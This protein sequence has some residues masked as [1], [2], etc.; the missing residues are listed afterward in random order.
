MLKKV[1]L[2][3]CLLGLI[4]VLPAHASPTNK[5]ITLS[6]G[7]GSPDVITGQVD[8]TL[9]DITG[10]SSV[11]CGLLVCDSSGG[12]VLPGAPA[13]NS[14]SCTAGFKVH[15][16]SYTLNYFDYDSAGNLIDSSNNSAIS[17]VILKG[18]GFSTQIGPGN[19]PADTVTLKVK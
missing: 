10:I 8:V 7:A 6:C 5:T 13:T 19:Y 17:G 18:S 2:L 16:M 3:F 11:D 15:D 1:L 9:Y 4:S 12:L 14:T